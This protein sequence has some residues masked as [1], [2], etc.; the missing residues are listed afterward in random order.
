MTSPPFAAAAAA[1][2]LA[3]AGSAAAQVQTTAA[4]SAA[5]AKAF[6]ESAE[7]QL[8]AMGE[9]AAKAA[10]VQQNFI[11]EDTE[12]LGSKA[13]AEQSELAPRLALEA[14]RFNGVAAD[15]VTARKLKLLKLYLTLPPP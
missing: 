4:P 14:A 7:A 10:W 3:A 2:I 11:T 8:A 13:D 15:P 5:E 1:L 9:Y 6:V 12:W